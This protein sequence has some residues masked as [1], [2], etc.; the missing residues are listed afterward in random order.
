[1]QL[2]SCCL[3]GELRIGGLHNLTVERMQG[4]DEADAAEADAV[5]AEADT[6][7]AEAQQTPDVA[8]DEAQVPQ[9]Q[10]D[11]TTAQPEAKDTAETSAP[12]AAVDDVAQASLSTDDLTDAPP[13]DETA[14]DEAEAESDMPEVALDSTE[15]SDGRPLGAADEVAEQ[16]RKRSSAWKRPLPWPRPAPPMAPPPILPRMQRPSHRYVRHRAS[17]KAP[18]RRRWRSCST[19][20]RPRSAH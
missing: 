14:A 11:E 10:A 19:S 20:R 18:S 6:A 4:T 2:G 15:E 5:T 16:S 17:T 7:T 9:T 12:T 3:P 8:S 1:V 13:A